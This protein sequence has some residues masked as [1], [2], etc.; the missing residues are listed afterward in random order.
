MNIEFSTE[1]NPTLFLAFVRVIDHICDKHQ[2]RNETE[3]LELIQQ[4]LGVKL[5]RKDSTSKT[6]KWIA[7]F[8][9]EKAHTLFILRWA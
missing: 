5:I 4:E 8:A 1:T 2:T 7:H 3:V 6:T 9:D